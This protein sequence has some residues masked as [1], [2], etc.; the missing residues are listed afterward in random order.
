VPKRY[1]SV[2][3]AKK[4]ISGLEYGL[5]DF[6]FLFLVELDT[7]VQNLIFTKVVEG[8]KNIYIFCTKG[9]AEIHIQRPFF[10]NKN[11]I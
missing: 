11:S 3:W 9:Y 7:C 5:L 8:F 6:T 10:D 2:L 4:T 1:N